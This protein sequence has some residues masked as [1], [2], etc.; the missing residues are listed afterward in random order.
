[1]A[2]KTPT[3]SKIPNESLC[4][5]KRI[6]LET[7]CVDL[8]GQLEQLM[9]KARDEQKAGFLGE[10]MLVGNTILVQLL[11]FAEAYLIESSRNAVTALISKGFEVTARGTELSSSQTFGTV[12]RLF[13]RKSATDFQVA[14]AHCEVGKA[15]ADTAEL[16]VQSGLDLLGS[17][18]VFA[19]GVHESLHPILVELR[20]KW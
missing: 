12:K 5:S 16:A 9:E 4:S 19:T 7:A 8:V 20:E 6:L 14:E 11:N 17:E 3:E 2:T 1:M 15:I 13:G 18:S 10:S